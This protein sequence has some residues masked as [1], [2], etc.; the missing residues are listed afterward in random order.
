MN[1][2]SSES[3][4]G[5]SQENDSQNSK[6]LI[7]AT[8]SNISSENQKSRIGFSIPTPVWLA[9]IAAIP[10]IYGSYLSYLQGKMQI[11]FPLL[12]TQTV[13]ALQT[14]NPS[15]NSN[16]Q[17]AV[18]SATIS[19]GSAETDS[20]EV[21]L[22]SPGP[23]APSV[24][25]KITQ[26]DVVIADMIIPPAGTAPRISLTPGIYEIEARPVYPSITPKSSNCFVQ[27]QLG[28]S[29]KRN[30]VITSN[31]AVIQINQY[32]L[33]PQEVCNTPTPIP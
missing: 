31:K 26:G 15:S 12:A 23:D 11:E 1:S 14:S 16:L 9:I 32:D 18:P 20:V 10:V 2:S 24:H 5:V 27:W 8:T 21:I 6:S 25:L 4:N 17:T 13:A 33:E 3:N 29:H 30:L 7:E 28:E 19:A 22:N